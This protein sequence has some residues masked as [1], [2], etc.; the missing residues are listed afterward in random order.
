M[1]TIVCQLKKEGILNV[2]RYLWHKIPGRLFIKMELMLLKNKNTQE[3]LK[4][5]ILKMMWRTAVNVVLASSSYSPWPQT[6][7]YKRLAWHGMKINICEC[8]SIWASLRGMSTCIAEISALPQAMNLHLRVCCNGNSAQLWQ[9]SPTTF[10][11]SQTEM[12]KWCRVQGSESHSVAAFLFSHTAFKGLPVTDGKKQNHH[13]SP[14]IPSSW[15][16]AC[17]WSEADSRCRA[18]RWCLPTQGTSW[19]PRPWGR[20]LPP[21]LSGN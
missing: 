19:L 16:W 10:F 5:K 20:E 2:S 12:L 1:K 21:S 13:I 18:A 17:V 8:S 15:Q 3:T 7:H 11:T 4:C 14:Q 6:G 9:S